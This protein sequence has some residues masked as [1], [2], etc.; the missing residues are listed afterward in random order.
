MDK[1]ERTPHYWGALYQLWHISDSIQ[2]QTA[3]AVNG[4]FDR[5]GFIMSKI[6]TENN[7]TLYLIRGTRNHII[8]RGFIDATKVRFEPATRENVKSVLYDF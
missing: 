3:V 4:P 2:P 6:R 1:V 8:Q 5:Y 7:R